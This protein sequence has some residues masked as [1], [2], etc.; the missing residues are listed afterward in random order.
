MIVFHSMHIC[1]VVS[2]IIV[3]LYTQF[4]VDLERPHVEHI[5]LEVMDIILAVNAW[6]VPFLKKFGVEKGN[7]ISTLAV[8]I[9]IPHAV[10]EL[11]K[12][13]FRTPIPDR[14][15]YSTGAV[16]EDDKE[17]EEA[18]DDGPSVGNGAYNTAGVVENYFQKIK[19]SEVDT[20]LNATDNN[21]V[22]EDTVKKRH[23][24]H[25]RVLIMTS[26]LIMV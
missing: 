12:K 24:S 25:P 7:G 6:M 5:W 11:V 4:K 8:S 26:P 14:R 21:A 19:K 15:G 10:G 20:A 13:H 1:N 16:D 3:I 2:P 22:E 17:A 9:D 23:M 18:D